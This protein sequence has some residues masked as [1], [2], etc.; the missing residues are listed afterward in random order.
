MIKRVLTGVLIILGLLVGLFLCA[1]FYIEQRLYVR[2]QS[3]QEL[4]D[5]IFDPRFPGYSRVD[6]MESQGQGLRQIPRTIRI[7]AKMESYPAAVVCPGEVYYDVGDP[8]VLHVQ[9]QSLQCVGQHRLM[10]LTQA[11][12]ASGL[13]RTDCHAEKIAH[14]LLRWVEGGLLG[15][16]EIRFPELRTWIDELITTGGDRADWRPLDAGLFDTRE[17]VVHNELSGE[18]EHRGVPTYVLRC[19]GALDLY[20]LEGHGLVHRYT[21][22]PV[23]DYL[24]PDPEQPFLPTP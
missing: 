5:L 12:L 6:I 16:E 3:D 15:L 20:L 21:E 22:I 14:V 2:P 11:A 13:T 10:E 17:M 23:G 8:M 1:S 18:V 24:L 4:L 19:N 9:W 7:E